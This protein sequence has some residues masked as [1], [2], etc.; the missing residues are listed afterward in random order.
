[1]HSEMAE[2]E[3]RLLRKLGLVDNRHQFQQTHLGVL[4]PLVRMLTENESMLVREQIGEVKTQVASFEETKETIRT[5]QASLR[6]LIPNELM[7]KLPRSFDVIGDIAVVD[8]PEG[9]E[10]FSEVIGKGVRQISPHVRLVLRRAS[11]VE[12]TFRTRK[13]EV[14]SGAGGTET[15]HRE[16][17]CRYLLDVSTVYFNPRLSG[18]RIRIARQVRPDEL[19]VDMFAGVGPYSVLIARLQPRSTVYSVDINPVAVKY[20]KENAFAN[21][22][23][24]RVIPMLGDVEELARVRLRG[25]ANRVIMNLPSV[26]SSYLPAA[27]QILKD[28]RGAIHFYAFAPRNENVGTIVESFRS[29]VE[30]RSIRLESIPFSKVIKEVGPNRV[31]VAIDALVRV[32]VRR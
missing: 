28:G 13:F 6:G 17:S 1:L 14:M 2:R 10:Q 27:V 18:E 4:V 8:L 30:S 29:R 3:L 12:G 31:Q 7:A 19:V 16:F 20:L 9:L 25:M 26:A 24:D 11:Q 21:S 5:L 22:V 23:A 32:R 15:V